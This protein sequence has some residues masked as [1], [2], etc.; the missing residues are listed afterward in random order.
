MISWCA[1]H[2]VVVGRHMSFHVTSLLNRV[3]S[4]TRFMQRGHVVVCET[5][6]GVALQN[7]PIRMWIGAHVADVMQQT[8][9]HGHLELPW[10]R[11]ARR[12]HTC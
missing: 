7:I 12:I 8:G 5:I 3:L 11:Q 2:F 9:L 10:Q 6:A 1:E 4:L